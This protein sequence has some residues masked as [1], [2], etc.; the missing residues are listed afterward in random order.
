MI[1][2]TSDIACGNGKLISYELKEDYE[3]IT[4]IAES[5]LYEPAPIWFHFQVDGLSGGDVRFVIGN[6]HQF[7]RDDP[8][9]GTITGDYPVFREPGGKWKRTPH[10]D[11]CVSCDGVPVS[12]FTIPKCPKTVEV[13]FCYP[14]STAELD[15]T[16]SEI[17]AFTKSLIGFSTKGRELYRYSAGSMTGEKLPSVYVTCRQ[18][19]A[20]VG[21]AWV[22]DGFLRYFGSEEGRA[23]LQKMNIWVVPMVDIDG[24]TEGC[25][26]KDQ[27]LGDMNRSW[28]WPFPLR[29]EI[30]AVI[31]DVMRWSEQCVP[32]FYIDFHS[33][34]HEV[35][36]MLFNIHSEKYS[37]VLLDFMEKTN[38]ILIKKGKEPFKANI[39]TKG[40]VGS[41]QGYRYT[42]YEFFQ[43]KLD[44]PTALIEASY[45]G[46]SD[47]RIFEIDDYRQYGESLARALADAI[48]N[49]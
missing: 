25:Y 31:Q 47:G 41:S 30:S 4:F 44:V 49:V 11:Y 8:D 21:G 20:E 5:K 18:H 3:Q 32:K 29:T 10:C 6:A 28:A 13:A 27:F 2:F 14:Y 38:K 1:S 42:S 48:G 15:E 24:V 12:W 16:M 43:N 40:Y 19:A 36:D 33:P 46:T 17:K 26:G 9:A 23:S 37:G 22:L 35:R 39:V 34:A 7:L 45:E